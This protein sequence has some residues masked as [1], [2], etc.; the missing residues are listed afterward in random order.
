MYWLVHNIDSALESSLMALIKM[1]NSKRES[2]ELLLRQQISAGFG[3]K[4]IINY[5]SDPEEVVDKKCPKE[6]QV[7]RKALREEDQTA[8]KSWWNY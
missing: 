7:A 3:L 1:A 2:Q 4:N 6:L 5:S 8:K